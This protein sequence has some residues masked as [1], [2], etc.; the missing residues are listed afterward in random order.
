ML[1]KEGSRVNRLAVD[2]LLNQVDPEIEEDKKLPE[3]ERRAL[4]YLRANPEK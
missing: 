3:E 1:I 2:A 4:E